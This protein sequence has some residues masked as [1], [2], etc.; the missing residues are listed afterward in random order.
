MTMPVA[1]LVR[2][3]KL[4]LEPVAGEEALQQAKWIVAAVIGTEPAALGIHSWMQA[5]Q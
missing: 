3:C 5:P 1:E 4:R 2:L